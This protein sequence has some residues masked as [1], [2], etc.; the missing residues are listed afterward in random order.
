MVL[1]KWADVSE[2]YVIS[3]YKFEKYAKQEGGVNAGGKQC[4]LLA[5]RLSFSFV[6]EKCQVLLLYFKSNWNVLSNLS[7]SV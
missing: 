3:I 6:H 7:R 2:E 4:L 1:S 5:N